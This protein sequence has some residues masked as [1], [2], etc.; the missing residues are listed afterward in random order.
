MTKEQLAIWLKDKKFGPVILV[1][2]RC[3]KVDIDPAKHLD[4]CDPGYEA[5]RQESQE[6]QWK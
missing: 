1:C 3:H 4:Q 5:Y 6:N 2:P